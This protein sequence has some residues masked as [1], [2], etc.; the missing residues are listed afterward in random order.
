MHKNPAGKR[1]DLLHP[2]PLGKHPFQVIH[3]DHLGP[4]ETNRKY[5]KYFLIIV[6]NLTKYVLLYPT[7]IINAAGVI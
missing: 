4:F 3:V 6:N 5:N 1:P 2:I 7:K